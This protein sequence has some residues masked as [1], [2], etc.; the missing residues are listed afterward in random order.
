MFQHLSV[1]LLVCICIMANSVQASDQGPL[2]FK[3][4]CL[5]CHGPHGWGRAGGI[6]ALAGQ[7]ASVIIRQLENFF[8]GRRVSMTMAPIAEDLLTE[9]PQW[10]KPL[11]QHIASMPKNPRPQQ[12]RGDDLER[13]EDTYKLKCSGCHGAKAQ[14]SGAAVIPAL[15]GQHYDY[16]LDQLNR[17]ATRELTVKSREMMRRVRKLSHVERLALA[18]YLS[19]LPIDTE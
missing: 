11:A 19:R 12:G 3:E 8:Q 5:V 4:R 10:I 15:N 2:V 18:D 9:H 13:G 7:H 14:G 16:I 17:F 6:P 1:V